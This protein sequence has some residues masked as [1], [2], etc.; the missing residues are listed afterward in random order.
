M[1]EENIKMIW[2]KTRMGNGSKRRH[3]QPEIDEE[4]RY[5]EESLPQEMGFWS[6]R[7]AGNVLESCRSCQEQGKFVRCWRMKSGKDDEQED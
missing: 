4:S 5:L 1:D 3:L 2:T 6:R 7:Q